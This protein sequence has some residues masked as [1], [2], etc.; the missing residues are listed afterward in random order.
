MFVFF[1][2]TFITHKTITRTY[3]IA[4]IVMIASVVEFYKE[5]SRV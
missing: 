2:S 3:A 1:P 4:R 5:N